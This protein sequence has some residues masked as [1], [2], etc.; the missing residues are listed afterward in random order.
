MGE[1]QLEEKPK[2][3][4]DCEDLGEHSFDGVGYCWDHF[5]ETKNKS[6]NK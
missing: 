1:Y 6:K 5:V 2:S 3:C 4:P